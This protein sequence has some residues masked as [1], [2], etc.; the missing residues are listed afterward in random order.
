[1]IEFDPKSLFGADEQKPTVLPTEL[2]FYV[3]T[4]PNSGR[5]LLVELKGDGLFHWG[6]GTLNDVERYAPYE[7]LIRES[8][9]SSEPLG[10]ADKLIAADEVIHVLID[11][12]ELGRSDLTAAHYFSELLKGVLE[13]VRKDER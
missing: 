7:R 8:E 2:G 12:G 3:G 6:P 9:K 1:M 10:V 11:S 13:E 4:N 5:K